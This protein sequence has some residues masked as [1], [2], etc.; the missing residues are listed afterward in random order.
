VALVRLRGRARVAFVLTAGGMA[1]AYAGY[2]HSVFGTLSPLARYGGEVPVPML[3]RTPLRTLVGLFVDGAYGLLPYAPVFL[4]ALAGL[5]LLLARGRRDGWAFA[6]AGLGVLLPVLG[7]RNWWGFSPPARFTIPLVPVLALAVAARLSAAPGRGLARWRWGLVAAGFA[8]AV[9]MFAEPHA[10]RMVN[11]RDGPPPAFDALGGEVSLARYL[12]Y[13][14]SRAGST[15][16]PWEPPPSEARVAAVWVAALGALLLL[17]R[18]ARSRDRVDGWFRGLALPLVLFLAVSI[19][20]DR[21]ARPGGPPVSRPAPT[22][23]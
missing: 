15:A 2:L 17:D 18:L 19:A 23:S 8:L 13:P 21:W 14:S 10:M 1:L 12:P 5:P 3:R 22:A 11:G 7:W 16:P 20:V 4:L 9:F 6:L